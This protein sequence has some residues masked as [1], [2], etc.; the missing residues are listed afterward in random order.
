M[1]NADIAKIFEEIADILEIKG[2]N[3]FR[4]RAYRNA[5]LKI[6]HLSE[7]LEKIVE[8]DPQELQSIPGIGKDL[9]A[10][11]VEAVETGRVTYHEKVLAQV[12]R[13]LLD[14]MKLQGVGPKK[15]KLFNQELRIRTVDD[16]EA[17]AQKGRLR[18]LPGMGE[19]SEKKILQA[20][21]DYHRREKGRI[22]LHR[23][24]PYVE[25]LVGY[26]QNAFRGIQVTPAG[27][28][29]RRKETIGDIDILVTGGDPEKVIGHFVKYRDVQKVLARGGTK[30]SVVL[31]NGLQVD[32]R[33][34]EKKNYGAA[35]YYFT[36]SKEHNVAV[37]DRAKRMGLKISEYGVFREKSGRRIGGET[38][39]E[40]FKAIGLHYIPPEM[41][42]NRGEIELAAEK[43]APRL[44]EL[45][46]IQGDLHM[47]TVA[48]D[49]ANSV[50]EM[51]LAARKLGRKYIAITDH[52]KA[53]TVANGL[54]EERML[55]HMKEIDKIDKKVKGIHVLKGVELD[56]LKDGSLDLDPSVLKRMDVVVGSVHS[57][58]DLDVDAMTKRII[59]AIE[60]GFIDIVGHPTGRIIGTRSPYAVDI[61]KV[62]D[63]AKANRVAMELNAYPNRL[64][65]NDIYCKMAR[66]KGVSIVISTDAHGVDQ[67][68]NIIYG[69]YEARRGWLE[70]KHVLNT[71]PYAEF[72][73]ALQR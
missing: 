9:A 37:R 15:V 51:A 63:A 17:A 69:V 52:S 46:D 6:A 14:L 54:D 27:S 7:R 64:D 55:Q 10:K 60:T 43:R 45:S 65:L 67:Q 21:V 53:V 58:F 11:I 4:I 23:V 3:P 18:N 35:L 71:K 25:A 49:G 68:K 39:E 2:E 36:G 73:K 16:L 61:E 32:L 33:V 26:I 12:P 30:A 48:S 24:L 70:K 5:A 13:T 1:E 62:M 20:I 50:E 47:H 66:D 57:Y 29:R 41:R 34:L 59:Q 38:E 40:I 22:P 56:I 8:R 44:I 42:E 19:K 31:R 28:V 72:K